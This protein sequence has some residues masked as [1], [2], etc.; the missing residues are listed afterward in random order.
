MNLQ[1]I[2]IVILS[3]GKKRFSASFSK[4]SKRVKNNGLRSSGKRQGAKHVING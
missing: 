1:M 2:I 3:F 4:L